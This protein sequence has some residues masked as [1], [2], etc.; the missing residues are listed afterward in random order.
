MPTNNTTYDL[1]RILQHNL[2]LCV[3]TADYHSSSRPKQP[4]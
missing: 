2:R 4:I 3:S 1:R